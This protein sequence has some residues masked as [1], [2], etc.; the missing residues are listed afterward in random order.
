MSVSLLLT[1]PGYVS[2]SAP[3]RELSGIL[4][5]IFWVLLW[6]IWP[7]WIFMI[8]AEHLDQIIVMLA[9]AAAFNGL[10]YGAVG[11]VIWKFRHRGT[12]QF[13]NGDV[14]HESIK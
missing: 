8:D 9:V 2:S 14:E 11:F 7:T 12:R 3:G 5:N 13:S 6:I 1:I 10:Y 4:E